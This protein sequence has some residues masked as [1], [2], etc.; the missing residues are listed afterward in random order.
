MHRVSLELG[1]PQKDTSSTDYGAQPTRETRRFNPL[2]V[3]KELLKNLPFRARP[4]V[5][6]VGH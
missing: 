6:I 3:P 2:R 5:L 1:V 4:K